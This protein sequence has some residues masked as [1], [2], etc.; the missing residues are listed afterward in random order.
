MRVAIAACLIAGAIGVMV[1][2]ARPAAAAEA[3]YKVNSSLS[4]DAIWAKVGDFCGIRA[5]HPAVRACSIGRQG[6]VRTVI[7]RVG[8]TFIDKL[9]SRDER[10]RSYT[11]T[12]ISTP[13]PVKD[14]TATL[15]VLSDGKGSLIT[16]SASF[17]PSR[18]K[19]ESG[20]AAAV[21]ALF[22]PGVDSL[23]RP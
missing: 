18:G 15:K 11:Y 6:E 3:V 19:G 12:M 16:W 10:A 13:L 8:G 14:C 17:K 5:W 2:G 9:V 7:L 1:P 4:P 23:A 22:K 20:A 21:V